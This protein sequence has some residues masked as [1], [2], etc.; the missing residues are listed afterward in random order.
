MVI[1]LLATAA[2]FRIIAEANS[3]DYEIAYSFGPYPMIPRKSEQPNTEEKGKE[4]E[5][6]DAREAQSLLHG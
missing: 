3:K 4:E 2:L 5:K 6:G 1:M